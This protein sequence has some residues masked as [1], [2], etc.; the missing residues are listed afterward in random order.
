VKIGLSADKFTRS[1]LFRQPISLTRA[2]SKRNATWVIE[3]KG[4]NP[5]DSG[6]RPFRLVL[7]GQ[8]QDSGKS[9]EQ[10]PQEIFIGQ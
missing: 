5:Y 6:R 4:W 2:M 7:L 10:Q 1:S 3:D 8:Q 9:K